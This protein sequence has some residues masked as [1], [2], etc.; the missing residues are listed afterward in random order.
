MLDGHGRTDGRDTDM[1]TIAPAGASAPPAS[2]PSPTGGSSAPTLGAVA[3]TARRSGSSNQAYG[4]A[5]AQ[6]APPLLRVGSS[7]PAV[8]ALKARLRDLHYTLDSGPTY[9]DATRHAV[10]AFQKVNGLDRDGVAGPVTQGAMEHPRRPNIG[11]GARNRIVVD[12]SQQVLL[13]V[14][15]GKLSKVVNATTGDPASP[16][17]KGLVTPQGTFKV[18]RHV[19]GEDNAPLGILYDPSYFFR[20]FAVHGSPGVG[21]YRA[22][23]G[24]VR[25][26]M[27]LSA[28]IQDAMPNGTQVTIRA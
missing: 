10:M 13:V 4:A 15:D 7:G 26:P 22:S 9:T 23:H 19:E 11:T 2:T 21:P 20:G 6:A 12:L 8:L 18:F 5:R 17:G 25:I 24:C 1:A 28:K 14:K 3:A 16:D 27:H